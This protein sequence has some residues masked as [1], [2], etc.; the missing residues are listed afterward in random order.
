M[1]CILRQWIILKTK[2]TGWAAVWFYKIVW[3]ELR[4]VWEDGMLAGGVLHSGLGRLYYSDWQVNNAI[5]G[6]MIWVTHP[7]CVITRQ[8]CLMFLKHV[9][10]KG[11]Q[12]VEHGVSHGRCRVTNH[13]EC[14]LQDSTSHCVTKT[15]CSALHRRNYIQKLIVIHC[16]YLFFD[17]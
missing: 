11:M 16:I 3:S 2:S 9:V 4:H 15:F 10:H 7:V 17:F 12:A 8:C 6:F 5:T 1:Q 14:F 13:T